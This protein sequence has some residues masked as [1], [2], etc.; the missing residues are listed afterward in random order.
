MSKHPSLLRKGSARIAVSILLLML[1]ATANVSGEGINIRRYVMPLYPA[2]S[3]RA[4]YEGTFVVEIDIASGS[5]VTVR[6]LSSDVYGLGNT[7]IDGPP[8]QDFIKCIRDALSRWEFDQ[9]NESER[10]TI[11]IIIEFR[12]AKTTTTADQ[13][14]F[15]FHVQ[16]KNNLP[17]KIKIEANRLGNVNEK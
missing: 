2:L 14:S 9:A 6:I 3:N 17:W 8:P 15:V 1:W 7:K 16:E 13:E 5:V 10:R 12:L 11:E 4:C